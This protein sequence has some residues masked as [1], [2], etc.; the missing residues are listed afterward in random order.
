LNLRRI[1]VPKENEKKTDDTHTH[2]HKIC[3][4]EEIETWRKWGFT[5]VLKGGEIL[6]SGLMGWEVCVL[7]E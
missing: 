2:T 1:P 7:N 6:Q 4:L 5:W 3:V